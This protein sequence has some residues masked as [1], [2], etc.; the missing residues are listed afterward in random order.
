MT[1]TRN[2]N[3][4][5]WNTADDKDHT[6]KRIEWAIEHGM[7]VCINIRIQDKLLS[8]VKPGDIVLAYEP[9]YHKISNDE[10]GK[11][12][13][14]M[15]C[16]FARHD[17]RQAMTDAFIMNAAP[18]KIT[19]CAEYEKYSASASDSNIF[20][21][22]FSLDKHNTDITAMNEYMK[23]YLSSGNQIYIFPCT[24]LGKLRNMISTNR[25]SGNIYKYYG[26]VRRGF[27]MLDDIYLTRIILKQFI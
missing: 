18:I 22:W 19:T 21:N 15:S 16:K 1:E 13:R 6:H 20:R 26:S 9:K 3:V 23:K 7:L 11:D 25:D 10:N 5:Y 8:R 4:F 24:Y 27:D 14:C 12:G 2:T 17:G